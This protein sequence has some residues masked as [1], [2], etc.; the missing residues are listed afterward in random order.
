MTF[1]NRRLS[2]WRTSSMAALV[3][4]AK[5]R[6]EPG[7]R[8]GAGRADMD[9]GCGCSCCEYEW[10]CVAELR[11]GGCWGSSGLREMGCHGSERG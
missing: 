7:R 4:A 11:D 9:G 8:R 10:K 1:G 5:L 6:S 3:P 2:W